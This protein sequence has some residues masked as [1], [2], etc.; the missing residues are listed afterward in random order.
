MS[1]PDDRPGVEAFLAGRSEAA[2]RG[3]YRR[4]TPALW[5]VAVRLLGPRRREAEDVIQEAWLRAAARLGRF[6]WRS[7][8]RTWL[9]GIVVHCCLEALRRGT[10]GGEGDEP[11]EPAGDG[12]RQESLATG[13][14]DLERALAGLPGRSRAVLVLH[15]VEGHTHE[16]IAS[17]LGIDEGTSKSQLSRARMRLRAQLGERAAGPGR[18]GGRHEGR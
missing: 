16:E 13:R 6:E 14:L 10:A 9:T 7:T 8:L 11:H 3:L 5:R 17:M 15:D 12:G 1:I 4:H 2:F 18:Q